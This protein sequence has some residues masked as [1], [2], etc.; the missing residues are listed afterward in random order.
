MANIHQKLSAGKFSGM[1]CLALAA[2]L[3]L[4][5]AQGASAQLPIDME[6]I[7]ITSPVAGSAYFSENQQVTVQV[8]NNGQFSIGGFQTLF[9][10]SV[11]GQ[12]VVLE[13]GNEGTILPSSSFSPGALRT[14]T[15]NGRLELFQPGLKTIEARVHYPGDRDPSNDFKTVQLES[16]IPLGTGEVSNFPY[17]EDFEN[18]AGGWLAY[19]Y[20]LTPF[21]LSTPFV[22]GTPNK[23][24]LAGAAS[25][26][27][28]WV[29]GLTANVNARTRTQVVSPTFDLRAQ[30]VM[31]FGLSAAW[32][33]APNRD[34]ARIQYSYDNGVTWAQLGEV[35]AGVNW[36]NNVSI[37]GL[38]PFSPGGGFSGYLTAG[39]SFTP[40]NTSG[41]TSAGTL[42]S[43]GWVTSSHPITG[44]Y[45]TRFRVI[46]G[47]AAASTDEGF[48]FDD[49]S[50]VPYPLT[51]TQ[52]AAL[53]TDTDSD[54][55]GDIG[56]VLRYTVVINNQTPDALG[57]WDYHT[58]PA[59][60]L[61]LV[62]GSVTT[63]QG[64]V[65]TGNAPLQTDVVVADGSFNAGA[66]V[67]IT[68]DATIVSPLPV[69]PKVCARG[70]FDAL[71]T[72]FVYSDDPATTDEIDATCFPAFLDDDND[73]TPDDTD[74]CPGSPDTADADNDTIP[75]ACDVCANG[76]DTIDSDGDHT[77]DACDL[78][79]TD[80]LK[81]TPG[82]CGCG[83]VDEDLN[84]NGV[85]DCVD[86]TLDTLPDATCG[87]S[88]TDCAVQPLGQTACA[89]VNGFFGHMNI[90]SLSNEEEQDLG[91]TIT[92]T[93]SFGN[94][95][96]GI[97]VVLDGHEKEDFNVN[98]MGLDPD[99]VATLCVTT[100]SFALG[101]WNG[102]VAIYKP[103]TRQGVN[104]VFGATGFDYVLHH[105]LQNAFVGTGPVG[106]PLN[107]FHLGVNPAANVTNWPSL[108]DG[109]PDDGFP[110]TGTM[111]YYA[112][113]GASLGTDPVNIPD[114]GRQ[115]FNGHLKLSPQNPGIGEALGSAVFVA[116]PLPGGLDPK[117]YMTS[118]RYFFDC[119]TPGCTDLLTAFV[120]P[121]RAATDDTIAAPIPAK[122]GELAIVESYNPTGTA[123][124]YELNA[125][126]AFGQFLGGQNVSLPI[127]A[128][129]HVVANRVVVNG[130]PQGYV[131][132]EESA[133]AFIEATSGKVSANTVFYKLG[134]DGKLSYA[135]S[136][137]ALGGV[138]EEAKSYFNS[139]LGQGNTT[140]VTNTSSQNATIELVYRNFIG[141]NIAEFEFELSGHGI[142]LFS[143]NLPL[144]S[145]GSVAMESDRSG[146]SLYNVL[147]RGEEYA[148]CST[149]R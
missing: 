86:P 69:A 119:T 141:A 93:D 140:I 108:G 105:Q 130:V 129:D 45:M 111:F 76:D 81:T 115:D 33:S 92:L 10:L 106:V 122:N 139:F 77:P 12:M 14:Y 68:F 116:N 8:R 20:D 22:L 75:D 46:Y 4:C 134:A 50:L 80:D 15:F 112:K 70:Y 128:V 126:G 144:D 7:S 40:Y 17:L 56:D 138:D 102:A 72:E 1:F 66:I 73:G 64:S 21:F 3:N 147:R 84:G 88:S 30:Q 136:M 104:P 57:G 125:V 107:T 148:V 37:E 78:C 123:A 91:A 113:G 38:A 16:T 6:I 42:G 74:L 51:V 2:I 65:V 100:N 85:F 67:T 143:P 34:G 5:G 120:V 127:H 52:T 142:A 18:G 11:N 95:E 117:F 49:I 9:S 44:G 60:G 13:G 28:A 61:A 124:A 54:G 39:S 135:Y 62:A 63:S 36:H 137:P 43:G 118:T 26:V 98:M 29:T 90:L 25:G 103:N 89:V 132:P 53:L 99:T 133:V 48:A 83:A 131:L 35:G 97:S 96:S 146:V 58:T 149:G 59:N 24:Y 19:D 41:Y 110:L 109:T 114:G 87:H 101:G 82:T 31:K 145:Y 55:R 79:P 71:Q 121:P 23:P 27:N 94:T 32:E 47:S